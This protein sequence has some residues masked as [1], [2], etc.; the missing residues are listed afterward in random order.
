[1]NKVKVKPLSANRTYRGTRSKP[2][3]YRKYEKEL[4]AALPNIKVAKRGNLKL[5]LIVH[6]SNPRADIDNFIKPFLDILQK[7]YSFDDNRVY[8][9]TATK[10]I[11]PKGEEAVSF[12][13]KAI[14]KKKK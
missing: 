11:V 4:L 13:L 2:Y 14:R 10:E 7:K 9:L 3:D 5:D 12:S 1:M 8:L 6:Y